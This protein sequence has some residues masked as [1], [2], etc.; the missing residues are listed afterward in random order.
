MRRPQGFLTITGE[1]S[2]IERDTATCGHCGKIVV[3]KPGSATT[4]YLIPHRDGSWHEEPGAGCRVCMRPVCLP[5]HDVGVC[6][7]FEKRLERYEALHRHL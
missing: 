1:R 4:V 5:C 6:V 3:V 7:P 2:L